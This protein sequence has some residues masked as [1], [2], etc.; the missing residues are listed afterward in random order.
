MLGS[1]SVYAGGVA[2][3]DAE[4]I[5]FNGCW[6]KLDSMTNWG[7][8]AWQDGKF[9]AYNDSLGVTINNA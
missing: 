6:N 3:E 1:A 4:E 2:R 9:A 7:S 8:I 5:R